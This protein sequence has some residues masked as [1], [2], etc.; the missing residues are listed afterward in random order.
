MTFS[1]LLNNNNN[2]DD[3]DD[4]EF[5][6]KNKNET[7]F[8]E[9]IP[10]EATEIHFLTT[11][12][13][14]TATTINEIK[15]R[16]FIDRYNLQSISIPSNI[17]TINDHAFSGCTN[18]TTFGF[19]VPPTTIPASSVP[20]SLNSTNQLGKIGKRAFHHCCSLKSFVIPSSVQIINEEAF[21]CCYT[22]RAIIFAS[23][24]NEN[25]DTTTT[26]SSTSYN[27][28][29]TPL[30]E[31][32]HNAFNRCTEL[33]IINLP[34]NVHWV[35]VH[36]HQDVL[37]HYNNQQLQLPFQ[38]CSALLQY[39]KSSPQET[40]CSWIKR[41]FDHLPLHQIGYDSNVS[42][43]KIKSL[44]LAQEQQNGKKEED[45][46]DGRMNSSVVVESKNNVDQ[47]KLTAL[48][49]IVCNP[50]ASPLMI[51][52]V[53]ELYPMAK[54]MRYNQMRHDGICCG[55][56]P[57]NLY[58][59]MNNLSS[60]LSQYEAVHGSHKYSIFSPTSSSS[61]THR[62][63]DGDARTDADTKNDYTIWQMI[64]R[65]HILNWNHI[66]H[67]MAIQLS[68]EEQYIQHEKSGLYP[69]MYAANLKQCHL[70]IVYHLAM[71]KLQYLC[72]LK[73]D[74]LK[75]AGDEKDKMKS[76]DIVPL[77]RTRK[78][79]RVK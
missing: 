27:T 33:V 55:I 37:P 1:F 77:N 19:V 36:P 32:C 12:A 54:Q 22:M 50:F 40:L 7:D 79:R 76:N 30:L 18:L 73:S 53:A 3:D 56:T 75:G 44:T 15:P 59:E 65:S 74:E 13:T 67:I 5:F 28:T 60:S 6:G 48:H 51:K 39:T 41:R 17:T 21:S 20:P 71:V 47:L 49:V 78:K 29:N 70:E 25:T 34:K 58:L 2:N 45:I 46:I 14:T 16:A 57:L 42:L 64:K 52:A 35:R 61:S 8:V 63:D 66:S 43:E 31:I 11:T 23:M 62:S 4:D 9:Q 72:T 68:Y 38:H 26:S 69:F 24:N 10:E